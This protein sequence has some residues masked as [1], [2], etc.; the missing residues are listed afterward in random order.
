MAEKTRESRQERGIN[1]RSMA[2][3]RRAALR[4]CSGQA[5]L[6]KGR[7]RDSASRVGRVNPAPTKTG[8]WVN[9]TRLVLRAERNFEIDHWVF[10]GD[11]SHVGNVK[12]GMGDEIKLTVYVKK[13]HAVKSAVGRDDVGLQTERREFVFDILRLAVFAGQIAAWQSGK[14]ARL[15][16]GGP[17]WM[18]NARGGLGGGQCGE[19][20][21][22]AIW[23]FDVE[24][25]GGKV[26]VDGNIQIIFEKRLNGENA[27]L[28]GIGRFAKFLF[29]AV[30]IGV[31]IGGDGESLMRVFGE[32]V[33]R[34]GHLRVRGR[35]GD[36]RKSGNE[37]RSYFHAG[38]RCKSC[39]KRCGLHIAVKL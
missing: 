30:G 23:I 8:A 4:L 26:H 5:A 33:R 36:K 35:T 28:V 13:N 3:R 10:G 14:V 17:S 38:D 18:C 39:T 20:R 37:Q 31:G 11:G 24:A 2:K 9:P 7:A 16:C 6:Q 32:V 12:R 22:F 27:G 15:R 34:G 25:D 19:A 29:R 21:V 1:N